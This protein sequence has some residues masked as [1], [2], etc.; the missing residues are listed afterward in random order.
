[1]AGS[2]WS[3][4][5]ELAAPGEGQPLTVARLL[6]AGFTEIGCWQTGLDRLDP[7]RDL[8]ALRGVYAFAVDE[9]VLYVG[10]ASRSIRQRLGFYARPGSSQRTNVR[11]NGQIRQLIG[12]G[13][14]VRVLI[15]H[16]PDLEWGKFRIS[17][18]EGLEAAL[19]EDFQ[20]PWN[21]KGKVAIAPASIINPSH[22]GTGRRV[23][24]SVP[25]AII[26]YVSAHPGCTELQIAKGVFGKNAVQPQANGYCRKLTERRVLERLPTRP[27]TYILGSN[28]GR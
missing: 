22:S 27:A 5:V 2:D 13:H 15:A 17:G 18:P 26:G 21:M 8:P 9:C 1:M 11:L 19:I 3:K 23:H 10:L 20:P 7:P 25:Q 28:A 14:T 4:P 24:G 6:A 12:E 16:P